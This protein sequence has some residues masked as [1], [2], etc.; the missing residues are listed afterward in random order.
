MLTGDRMK[1]KFALAFLCLLP[2]AARAQTGMAYSFDDVMELV[3]GGLSSTS[4]LGR[5]KNGC[6]S[7]R[8]TQSISDRLRSE[9]ANS[10]LIDGLRATC[11]KSDS[12]SGGDTRDKPP[13]PVVQAC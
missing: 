4:I 13:T 11:Y 12:K 1:L 8:V 6:I 10:A 9:G 3:K 2:G 5:V 7:F